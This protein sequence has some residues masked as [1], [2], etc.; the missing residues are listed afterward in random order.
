MILPPLK[1]EQRTSIVAPASSGSWGSA[2]GDQ[3]A[4]VL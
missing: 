2:D 4:S 3:K 1:K